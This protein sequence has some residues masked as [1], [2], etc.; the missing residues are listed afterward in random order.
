MG[1]DTSKSK[2][3]VIDFLRRRT[4]NE[5]GRREAMFRPHIDNDENWKEAVL[6]AICLLTDTRTSMRICGKQVYDYGGRGHTAVFPSKLFHE[7]VDAEASTWKLV[8]FMKFASTHVRHAHN[9]RRR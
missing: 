4:T 9:L 5:E 2:V 1:L 3:F 8:M 6:T 7:T